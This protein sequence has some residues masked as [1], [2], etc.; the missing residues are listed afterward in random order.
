MW[1]LDA[2]KADKLQ[3]QKLLFKVLAVLMFAIAW[4]AWVHFSAC[5]FLRLHSLLVQRQIWL[6]G[7]LEDRL[8]DHR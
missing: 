5:S 7:K 6:F 3:P 4:A 2:R 8:H 1:L